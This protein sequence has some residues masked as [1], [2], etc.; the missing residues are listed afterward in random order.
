LY[1]FAR[2]NPSSAR[3]VSIFSNFVDEYCADAVLKSN[4][5]EMSDGRVN[6]ER[7]QISYNSPRKC[8]TVFSNHS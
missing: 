1:S 5:H 8:E 4:G 3:S 2:K 6:A 7:K